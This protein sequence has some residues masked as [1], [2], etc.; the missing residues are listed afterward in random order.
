MVAD[1]VADMVAENNDVI[2]RVMVEIDI[3]EGN[4]GA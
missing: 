1:V 4:D 3:F 2:L